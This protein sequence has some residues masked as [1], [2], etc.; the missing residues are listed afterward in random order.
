MISGF[1]PR[2][3]FLLYSIT[4]SS[5]TWY[6]LIVWKSVVFPAPFGPM[7][8][9]I[10]PLSTEKDTSFTATK[11]A[12]RFVTCSSFNNVISSTPLFSFLRRD[13]FFL[14]LGFLVSFFAALHPIVVTSN[15][16]LRHQQHD[17]DDDH[18][19]SD[20]VGSGTIAEHLIR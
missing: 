4:P 16:P 12:N 5:A 17:D 11:P 6:P 9:T 20:Q 19:V 1:N 8:P 3:F 14:F 13:T 18:A 15:D 10:S 7:I 2:I